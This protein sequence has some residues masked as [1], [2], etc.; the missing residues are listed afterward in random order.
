MD[1]RGDNHS[2][3]H[4]SHC[5]EHYCNCDGGSHGYHTKSSSFDWLWLVACVVGGLI[6]PPLGSIIMIIWLFR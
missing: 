2:F 3:Y 4:D 5:T 6:F 1:H